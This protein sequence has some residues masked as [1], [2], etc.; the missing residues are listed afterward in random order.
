MLNPD[1]SPP[2]F[3][4]PLPFGSPPRPGLHPGARPAKRS[5]VDNLGLFDAMQRRRPSVEG[6][7]A[8]AGPNR[9]LARPDA[10]SAAR[11]AET[12]SVENVL[13]LRN[14]SSLVYEE[15]PAVELSAEQLRRVPSFDF[16]LSE[17]E[18]HEYLQP[19]AVVRNANVAHVFELTE[20]MQFWGRTRRSPFD[21]TTLLRSELFRVSNPA[22]HA[23]AT[24]A[25]A[26]A[27]ATEP[28]AMRPRL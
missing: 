25:V 17:R 10:P 20:L 1:K 26:E 23:G 14:L 15:M 8:G 16:M 21:N 4:L 24:E 19:V 22:V 18:V 5:E 13:F 27:N 12:V 11:A 28:K 2:N 9:A 3:L 7:N 6:I